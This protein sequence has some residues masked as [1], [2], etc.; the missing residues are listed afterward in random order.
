MFKPTKAKTPK[1]YIDMIDEPR[2]SDIQKIHDFIRKTCPTLKPY[3]ES[4]MIG[5]GEMPYKYASGREGTWFVIGLASQKNYISIYSCATSHG[6]YL[7]EKHKDKLGKASIGK[8]CIRYKKVE[9]IPWDELKKV[10]KESEK[11]AKK[12][13]IFSDK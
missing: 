9:D 13:G 1:E 11:I 4:G 8:S 10:L 2:R 12:N 7:A 5:Y 6:E 3:I